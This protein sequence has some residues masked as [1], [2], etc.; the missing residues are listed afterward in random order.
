MKFS[1]DNINPDNRGFPDSNEEKNYIIDGVEYYAL[2]QEQFLPD[3]RQYVEESWQSDY[4]QKSDYD[5]DKIILLAGRSSV[6]ADWYASVMLKFREGVGLPVH[7]QDLLPVEEFKRCK[8][9]INNLNE[10]VSALSRAKQQAAADY[11]LKLAEIDE[12]Y[13]D[14]QDT[15]D[16]DDLLFILTLTS[17]DLPLG[18]ID[19]I[20]DYT[21]V[22]VNS[23][24]T[25]KIYAREQL[26]R[27]Q[28]FLI[29]KL[30]EGED[31]KERVAQ[32]KMDFDF[33]F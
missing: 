32:D 20:A 17:N 7:V 31:I 27:Y 30:K 21:P 26:L 9:M 13:K 25:T 14:I 15:K 2:K 3:R 28:R 24:L 1:F 18:V 4:P 12:Q 11:K 23:P 5:Y 6:I 19:R 8:S 22:D 29:I 33:R 10:R 16:S